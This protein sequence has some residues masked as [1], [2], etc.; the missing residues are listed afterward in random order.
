MAVCSIKIFNFLAFQVQK[1]SMTFS[2][3]RKQIVDAF[4]I[5]SSDDILNWKKTGREQ[6]YR[7]EIKR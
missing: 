6:I 2:W 1:I 4:K 3:E 7:L 5:Y